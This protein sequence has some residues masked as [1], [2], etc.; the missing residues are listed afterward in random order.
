[1]CL[2][3]EREYTKHNTLKNALKSTIFERLQNL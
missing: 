1:M 3:R 2:D